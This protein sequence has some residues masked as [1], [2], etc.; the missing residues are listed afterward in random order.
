MAQFLLSVRW[1]SQHEVAPSS[2]IQLTVSALLEQLSETQ[3]KFNESIVCSSREPC[4]GDLWPQNRALLLR[5]TSHVQRYNQLAPL[6]GQPK[7]VLQT[8]VVE[9][10]V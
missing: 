1:L 10:T 2:F 4:L 8:N 7:E 9:K 3:I 6:E 5:A